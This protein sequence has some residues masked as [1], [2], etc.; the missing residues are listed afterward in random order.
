LTPCIQKPILWD[1][2]RGIG[3]CPV[4]INLDTLASA[5]QIIGAGTIITAV[6]FGSFQIREY[7]RRRE[8][9]VAAEIMR[10]FYGPD[11]ARAVF[12]IQTLPDAISANELRSQGPKYEE[13]AILITTTFETMG[14]LVFRN[15]APFSLVQELAGGL[16]I[17]TWKKLSVWLNAVREEQS[18]P[19][20][21]EWYE[22]LALQMAAV[23]PNSEP[24]H[25]KYQNWKPKR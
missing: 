19:S 23:K 9:I 22:W 16:I 7:R 21:A 1:K 3:W 24:A 25:I 8:N 11:F 14:L 15:I 18:Q 4:N 12:L 2:L 17:V 13:A 5:A 10:S 6:I 20:W